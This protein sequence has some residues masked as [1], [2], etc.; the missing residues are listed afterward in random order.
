MRA[1]TNG[2]E[3]YYLA[4]IEQFDNQLR[5]LAP[6]YDK[7]YDT[8]VDLNFRIF[9]FGKGDTWDFLACSLCINECLNHFVDFT[10]L[11]THADFFTCFII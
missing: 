9:I 7:N 8:E 5:H 11:E 1:S 10:F 2:I 6:P 4:R 3:D